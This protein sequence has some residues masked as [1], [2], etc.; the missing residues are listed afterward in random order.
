MRATAFALALVIGL[1]AAAVPA[2]EPPV[3]FDRFF[4]DRTLRV[5][6][7]HVGNAADEL[8]A[9]DRVL[10]GGAWAGSRT[11][12]LDELGVG[13]KLPPLPPPATRTAGQPTSALA[14]PPGPPP[15]ACGALTTRRSWRRSRERRCAW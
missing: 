7:H 5:D 11:R 9:L 13:R 14:A 1:V 4:I 15:P 6:V 2:A 10:A 12:L 3:A 8:F